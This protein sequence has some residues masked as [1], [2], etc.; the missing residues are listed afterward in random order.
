[1]EGQPMTPAERKEKIEAYGSGV[2]HLKDAIKKFPREMWKWKP[3]PN[4]WSI[5]EIL[6]HLADS[7][8]NAYLR[9]RRFLAEPGQ[10]VMAYDQDLWAQ[11]LNYH[12]QNPDDAVALLRLV[13][14]MTY[15]LIR[16]LPDDVWSRTALH[17]EHSNYTFE[18]WLEIYARHVHGH[19][20]QMKKNYIAWK[21]DRTL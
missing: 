7:E 15:A 12:D 3:A 2:A 14:K 17:P 6:V 11:K 16:D 5:H 20:E 18:R 8:A 13:R 21:A 10:P 9:A 19:V 1:M 4:R